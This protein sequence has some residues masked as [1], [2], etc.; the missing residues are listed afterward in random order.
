MIK[1]LIIF[2]AMFLL[3]CFS[4]LFLTKLPEIPEDDKVEATTACYFPTH[5]SS[6]KTENG[7]E[8]TD[9]D[10]AQ[11]ERN[12][13]T[14]MLLTGE[15][16]G[17]EV[18]AKSGE[19]WL[20]LF[21]EDDKYFLR[22]AKIKV[23]RVR[24]EIVDED[25]KAKTGKKVSIENKIEPIFLLDKAKMLREGEITTLYNSP[26]DEGGKQMEN[27]F[28]ESYKLDGKIYTLKV[29]NEKTSETGI[30][31][32]SKLVLESEETKQVLVSLPNG[33]NDAFWHLLWVGDLDRDGKLDFYADV[34]WHHNVSNPVLFLSS[35]AEK[36]KLVKDVAD[37]R[38]VGC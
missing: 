10:W 35:Q 29:V 31:K 15:F 17:D 25:P 27:G 36:G 18:T 34:S 3:G 32:G 13:K 26:K 37:F 1:A 30:S 4:F 38:S 14:K 19:K 22:Y 28:S 6:F 12:Y 7:Q 24:D 11:K 21:K 8:S 16:H 2:A 20:G 33:G 23:S 9:E 5:N